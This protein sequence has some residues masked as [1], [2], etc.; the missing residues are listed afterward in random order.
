MMQLSKMCRLVRLPSSG[1]VSEVLGVLE[2]DAVVLLL[3]GDVRAISVTSVVDVPSRQWVSQLLGRFVVVVA[4]SRAFTGIFWLSYP[5]IAP[6]G[7]PLNRTTQ[8]CTEALN[9][10]V[11]AN[12][13]S[14]LRGDTRIRI[15]FDFDKCLN[16]LVNC[17][18]ER[19]D[20]TRGCGAG[21]FAD[22]RTFYCGLMGQLSCAVHAIGWRASLVA[23]SSVSCRPHSDCVYSSWIWRSSPQVVIEI[24][25]ALQSDVYC[26]R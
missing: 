20:Q 11:L 15:R 6:Y 10:L 23:A 25:A 3:R 9:I 19:L 22:V 16:V 21:P 4:V 7:V 13:L 17:L 26:A 14:T 12:F 18:S 2:G 24:D 5:W 8:L 1:H